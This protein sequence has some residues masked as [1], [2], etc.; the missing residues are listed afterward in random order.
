MS[1]YQYYEFLAVDRALTK[2]EI[3]EVRKM[4]S[5]ANITATRFV[6]EC[7]ASMEGGQRR[8]AGAL[9]KEVGWE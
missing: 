5:R 1:E 2:G 6:N 7:G 8:T 4:S 9:R 3:A